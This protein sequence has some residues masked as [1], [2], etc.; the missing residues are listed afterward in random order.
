MTKATTA[1]GQ[2][3]RGAWRAPAT[4]LVSEQVDRRTESEENRRLF[5]EDE[6]EQAAGCKLEELDS[7]LSKVVLCGFKGA[8]CVILALRAFKQSEE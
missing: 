2:Q 1:G 3:R 6:E 4:N 5:G 8:G 7:E